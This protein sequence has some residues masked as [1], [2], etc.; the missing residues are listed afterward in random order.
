MF[1][2]IDAS[3]NR[4]SEGLRFLE[5]ASR[6]LLNDTALTEKLKKLRHT[7]VIGEWNFQ[8]SMIQS[9]NSQGDVGANLDVDGGKNKK[10]IPSAIVANSRRVQEALRTLEEMAKIEGGK[11]T[12]SAEKYQQARFDIYAIEKELVARLLRQDKAR[13]ITGLYAI[14]DTRALKGR[15]HL[16]MAHQIIRGGARIIQLRDKTTIKKNLLPIAQELKN[17]CAEN[18]VLFIM[19]DA[20]DIALAVG[21]DGLHIGQEDLPVNIARKLTPIDMLIGCSVDNAAQAQKAIA[22]GADYVAVGA[23]F[24]TPTKDTTVVGPDVLQQVRQSTSAPL[25][26]IGGITENNLVEVKKARADSIAVISAILNTDSP[27]KSTREII[28]MFEV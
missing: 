23:I 20:L 22:D 15:N 3:L 16:E 2:V 4:A 12:G 26:A 9:R 7:L 17:I 27:E 13:R 28:K 14:I 25:V 11:L 1:R 8:K 6:F 21:A 18:N 5:D 19:N 10:D 24:P